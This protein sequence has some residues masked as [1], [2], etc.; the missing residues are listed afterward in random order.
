MNWLG[1]IS[2]PSPRF[3]WRGWDRSPV[4]DAPEPDGAEESDEDSFDDQEWNDYDDWKDYAMRISSLELHHR[5][6]TRSLDTGPEAQLHI[7]NRNGRINIRTHDQ[8]SIVIDV[9]A[10]VYA[11]SS[12]GADRER[13]RIERGITSDG[14]RVSVVAPE[15]S[16]PEWFFFGRGPRIDYDVRVPVA[17]QV[18]AGSRNGH[19]SLTGTRGRVHVD[20]RNGRVVIDRVEG[21]TEVESRNGGVNLTEVSGPVRVTGVNGPVTIART[22]E[23]V[24][25]QTKNGP[26]EVEGAGSSV[27]AKSSNGPIRFQGPVNGDLDFEAANGGI[28]VAVP[29]DAR[30]E[31]DAESRHG[32]TR[33]DLTVRDRKSEEAT[34]PVPKVKIR[35]VN[36][37]IRLTEV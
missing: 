37:G 17:T 8:P 4:A 25:V 14:N 24:E 21:E 27:R 18:W 5:S 19:V 26:I 29:A 3:R 11:E 15:L 36:G 33:S 28:R 20:S 23:A 32:S 30:F 1:P 34:G 16:R 22:R 6:F 2:G 10:D 35:T 13:D 31:I 7:E 12:E 9:D